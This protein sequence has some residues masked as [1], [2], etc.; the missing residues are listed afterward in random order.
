VSFNSLLIHTGTIKESAK[1][2]DSMRGQTLA[3]SDKATNV[4]C[5][6]Q[7][8]SINERTVYGREGVVVTHR[9]FCKIQSFEITEQM[10]FVIGSETFDIEGV[11]KPR[12]HHY[13][14]ITRLVR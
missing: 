13:E 11:D 10:R 2:N 5:Y 12:D 7:Q 6:K 8:L 3:W 14:L 1:T 4:R 9:I